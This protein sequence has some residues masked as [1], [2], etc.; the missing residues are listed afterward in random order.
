MKTKKR[1]Q[2]TWK[3]HASY[4]D[5]TYL[6]IG[7]VHNKS[8]GVRDDVIRLKSRSLSMELDIQMR[9]DEAVLLAA[10]LTKVAGQM[11]IGQLPMTKL[12]K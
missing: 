4:A 5:G 3:F 6:K 9:I 2:T 12:L 8:R 7:Y 1:Q 10:G 11:L